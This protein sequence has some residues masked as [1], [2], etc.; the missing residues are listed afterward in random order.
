MTVKYLKFSQ[1]YYRFYY[2]LRNKIF[3]KSY[4]YY[5]KELNIVEVKVDFINFSCNNNQYV[6]T[7]KF[8][9]L[10]ISHSFNDN[11]DWNFSDYG[12]L[13][14][15]NLNYFDFLN[16]FNLSKAKGLELIYDFVESDEKVK[17]GKEP[18]PI[19]LRN[20]NW[21]KFL[22]RNKV[23]NDKINQI[24]F[25]HYLILLDN[26]EYH[27]LGNHLLENGFSLLF[28]AY[29][30]KEKKFYKKARKIII[31]EL[32]EQILR[33][34]A[35]F[36]LSPMYHQIILLRLLECVSLLNSNKWKN[37]TLF[38]EFLKE[39]ASNMLSY[40]KTITYDNGVIP[41]VNDSAYGIAPSSKELFEYADS[42]KLE[43]DSII[44]SESGYRK[45]KNEFY[46]LFIDIGEIGPKYQAGHAHADML[47]FELHCKS[48]PFI[49][50]TGTS[51]YEKNELRQK[52]RGTGSHNTVIINS[53]NQS[54]VWGGFRVASRAKIVKSKTQRY[55]VIASHDGYKKIAGQH[56]REFQ[57][58]EK[59]II[60][61]DLI[62]QEKNKTKNIANFHFY[63]DIKINFI[64]ENKVEF[65]NGV[66]ML[67]E[68]SSKLQIIKNK[69]QLAA[70]FNKT[71]EAERLSV[72]FS[73]NLTTHIEL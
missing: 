70:G 48:R 4:D 57:S 59:R 6:N 39:K 52:E 15:Y 71:I 63:S 16:Q 49:V 41:M 69:Y 27:L 45:F 46:E 62:S 58:E 40:L 53:V 13:W 34:G 12:K 44:L 8:H 18:Y 64:N 29:F 67:F 1:I 65:N 25:N 19:S 66:K 20:I 17:V 14:S 60:V 24:L 37:D 9:F 5:N 51:T 10:N 38:L 28:G 2:V 23:K 11:I 56:Y 3:H 55:K 50:D 22:S 42:L 26:L 72:R 35:H 31:K 32:N 36:E 54:Q 7:N 30:F 61:K 21:I 47:N 68:S 33:D 73:N 43:Y